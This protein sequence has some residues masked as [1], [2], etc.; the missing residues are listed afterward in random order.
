MKDNRQKLLMEGPI[1][2][3]LISLAIPIIL[4]NFL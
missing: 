3:A 1:A 2:A 4:G